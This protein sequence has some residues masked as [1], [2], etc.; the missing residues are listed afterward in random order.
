[1]TADP[2]VTRAIEGL[3]P[4]PA[5]DMHA[6]QAKAPTGI[7]PVYTA[8]QA[9]AYPLRHGAERRSSV[10]PPGA[11]APRRSYRRRSS[12]TC[13]NTGRFVARNVLGIRRGANSARPA[14]ARQALGFGFPNRAARPSAAWL[15]ALQ[16]ARRQ[17]VSEPCPQ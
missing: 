3:L 5:R 2:C 17:A 4:G 15:T 12:S 10:A 9:A 8:L 7:E 11:I 6:A 14:D 1:M 16:S 13:W